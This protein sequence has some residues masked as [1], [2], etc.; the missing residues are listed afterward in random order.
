MELLKAKI[1]LAICDEL[2]CR[3]GAKW[4]ELLTDYC[5]HCIHRASCM[6]QI[7]NKHGIRYSYNSAHSCENNTPQHSTLKPM[8]WKFQFYHCLII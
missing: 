3:I 5:A 7:E 2:N 4:Y 1:D 6:L 8:R